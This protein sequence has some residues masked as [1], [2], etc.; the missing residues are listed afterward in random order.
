M[1]ELERIEISS[2][3]DWSC[4][5]LSVSCGVLLGLAAGGASH[6]AVGISLFMGW[7]V[8]H[9]LTWGFVATPVT[10]MR[11]GAT[12]SKGCAWSL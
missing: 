1:R 9:G 10:P 3:I 2:L 8:L 4:L 7:M 5:M 11:N 12:G 6:W